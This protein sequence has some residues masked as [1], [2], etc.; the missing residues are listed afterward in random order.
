M[1][2]TFFLCRIPFYHL[3]LYGCFSIVLGPF[4]VFLFFNKI[5]ETI[6]LK[7]PEADR[8]SKFHLAL[9][10]SDDFPVALPRASGNMYFLANG[11]GIWL[12]AN[13]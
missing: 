7:F 9:T 2:Y 5:T 4:S 6:P 11:H 10:D 3:I 13:Y 8:T 12:E 1:K